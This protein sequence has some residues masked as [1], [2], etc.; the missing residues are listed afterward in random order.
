M[1]ALLVG[2]DRLGAWGSVRVARARVRRREL[3][4]GLQAGR[5]ITA[6]WHDVGVC[7]G[8]TVCAVLAIGG[9]ATW[10]LFGG[11]LRPR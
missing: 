11:G 4:L 5:C 9:M 3:L 1:R 10:G 8:P 2:M 6:G 7:L